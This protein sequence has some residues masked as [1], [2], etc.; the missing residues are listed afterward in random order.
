MLPGERALV[1]ITA[2]KEGGGY[3]EAEKV[4]Q[5][6]PPAGAVHPPCVHIVAC[7]GCQLQQVSYATQLQL[8][9]ML[10][11]DTLQRIGKFHDVHV[12]PVLG[13]PEHQWAYRNNMQFAWDAQN[14]RLGLH[15]A[16]GHGEV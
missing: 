16:G 3:A 8:K 2:D 14:Q 15:P 10:V 5:I 9:H 13:C 7:G 12:A 1:H 6:H 4:Q 11:V